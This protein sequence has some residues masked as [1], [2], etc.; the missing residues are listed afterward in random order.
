MKMFNRISLAKSMPITVFIL[1]TSALIAIASWY[2]VQNL[3]ERKQF[4]QIQSQ[5]VMGRL[6]F[7]LE[8]HDS[9]IEKNQIINTMKRQTT[10]RNLQHLALI[11]SSQIIEVAEDFTLMG[12][13]VAK[14]FPNYNL[15]LASSQLNTH[16]PTIEFLSE[17]SQVY[18]Y[19]PVKISLPNQLRHFDYR[20]LLGVFDF[21][22]EFQDLVSETLMVSGALFLIN[23]VINGIVYRLLTSFL[24]NPLQIIS[25]KTRLAHQSDYA[26]PIVAAGNKELVTLTKSINEMQRTIRRTIS[27]LEHNQLLY[28]IFT[29]ALPQACAL[30]TLSGEVVA[31][32]GPSNSLFS[33]AKTGQNLID[34][35]PKTAAILLASKI[36][37]SHGIGKTLDSEIN[38]GSPTHPEHYQFSFTPISEPIAGEPV[39]L[40]TA[41]DIS[42]RK[43][44][45]QTLSLLASVFESREAIVITDELTNIV[46]V[47]QEFCRLTGYEENEL[48]AQSVDLLTSKNHGQDFWMAIWQKVLQDGAW[49]GELTVN[50]KDGNT[51]PVRQTV[52]VVRDGAGI[53][54]NYVIVFSDISEQKKAMSLVRYHAN[55]DTLTDL[56]N[57]RLFMSQLKRSMA[58]A[59]RH[60]FFSALIF[61]DLDNFKQINDSYGHPAGDKLLVEV[62]SQIKSRIRSEDFVAR[63]GGDEFVVL[64]N[65]LDS[66]ANL[67]G[68]YALSVAQNLLR[69][70]QEQKNIDQ[71]SFVTTASL[72]ITLFPRE[73][74]SAYDILRE[75]DTAMY[76][77]KGGGRNQVAFFNRDMQ[78]EV[79]ATLNIMNRLSQA[80]DKDELSVV[81]Q[82]QIDTNHQ[83]VG[84]EALV[85]WAP[86]SGEAIPPAKFIPIAE[87]S[88]MIVEIGDFVLERSMQDLHELQLRGFPRSFRRMAVNISPRQFQDDRFENRVQEIVANAGV[89]PDRVELEITESTLVD[90]HDKS[91]NTLN[92]LKSLGFA[93]AID[94]FGTGYSSLAYLKT[95]PIEKLKID[96]YFVRDISRDESDAQIVKTIISMAHAMGLRVIAEGVEDKEQLMFLRAN[97]CTEYQGYYFSKPIGLDEFIRQYSFTETYV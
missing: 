46:R 83:L 35:L 79:K 55:F 51:I 42:Q 10:L 65:Q 69:Q 5:M 54:Q 50:Q 81:Y 23:L 34:K 68:N 64:L 44:H 28:Q 96:Q 76:Q 59:E 38:L 6:Q 30:V 12:R 48:K 58:Q 62:A 88:G 93:F 29:D 78:N 80:V 4:W 37:D 45:E 70:I 3:E 90:N 7:D 9:G 1:S 85:R 14:E 60:G 91:Q 31:T 49:M 17:S 87:D 32:Y 71:K 21:R 86:S 77:A 39:A 66:D 73:G 56:P 43:Q 2:F 22:A 67:A 84:M 11:D 33:E 89:L 74:M 53:I 13:E 36:K 94:D 75:A 52:S 16:V 63:L 26:Q 57:R 72:G 82:P 40:V 18:A 97:L 24:I 15:A 41:Q 8:Q 95:L 25:Q 20:L 19:Y 47:N 92:N 61:I 27:D